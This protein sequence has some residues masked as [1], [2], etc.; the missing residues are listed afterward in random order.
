MLINCSNCVSLPRAGISLIEPVKTPHCVYS[1]RVRF[2]LWP[3]PCA[4]LIETAN[5]SGA[6]QTTN[7]HHDRRELPQ[8]QVQCSV[9]HILHP[10]LGNPPAVELLHDRHHVLHQQAEGPAKRALRQPDGQRHAG[11]RRRPQRPG[12]QVQQRDDLV[13]HGALARLYLPQLLHPPEDPSEAAHLGQPGGHPGGLP[14][15]C[16]AGE[17]GGGPAAL[18]RPHHDQDHLH[19]LVR[20]G[21]AGQPVRTG[22]DPARLL[23]HAHHERPGPRRDLRR[24]LHDLRPGLRLGPAGQRLRLLHHGLLRYSRRHHLLPR[25]AQDGVFPSL[26]GERRIRVGRRRREQDGPSQTRKCREVPC[27]QSDGRPRRSGR[28]CAQNIPQ[29]PGDGSVRVL[30]LH[31]HHRDLSGRHRRGQVHVGRRGRLGY[32]FHPCVVFPPLQ[33]DGLGWPQPDS[34]LHV[35]RQGQ[36]LAPRSGGGAAGV[37][38]AL[39]AV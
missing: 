12:V 2:E 6:L 23:H 16:V 38:A 32:V 21:S 35:A 9:A 13:R 1:V 17:G 4:V 30:H 11:R 20:G 25:S 34:R 8:R 26:R 22:G 31:R 3:S 28:V 14:A 15:D 7:D 19:Q 36:P 37:C 10:G 24:L 18:L 33:R 39:H 5:S 27:G 29:D